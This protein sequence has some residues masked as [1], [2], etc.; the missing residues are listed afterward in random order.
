MGAG[1]NAALRLVKVQVVPF[2][3]DL[4]QSAGLYRL[5][6]EQL[7]RFESTLPAAGEVR[8]AR[9][10]EA[11]LKARWA[12]FGSDSGDKTEAVENA[13]RAPGRVVAPGWP[14]SCIG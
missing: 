13:H 3:L 6:E 8:L 12:G 4:N 1:L 5:S 2:A 10:F 14:Q 7:E 9:D 11:G